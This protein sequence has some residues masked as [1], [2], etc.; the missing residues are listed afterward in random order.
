MEA[1]MSA[2]IL[3]VD[4]DPDIRLSLHDRLLGLN[5][6]V[7]QA[8]SCAQARE[9]LQKYEL[10]LILL[11]L[12]LPDGEGLTVLD[13]VADLGE[14]AEVIVVSAY[15]TVQKAVEAM[16][17]GVSDFVT[18]PF[19]LTDLETRIKKTLEYRRLKREA[20]SFRTGPQEFKHRIVGKSQKMTDCLQ[21]CQ[22]LAQTDTTVL[23]QG[24]TGTGKE[25]LAHYIHASGRRADRPFVVL[26]C[27]N[28][29]A[30]LIEDELFGHE[31]GAFTGAMKL[32]QGKVE[33]AD[34]GTLF[35]DEIGE[36]PPELQAKLLRFL[37]EKRY[38]RVGGNKERETD[39]RL[40]A[41][42]NRDLAAAV[43]KGLFRQDLYFRLNVYPVYLSP[44]RER[45]EDISDLVHHFGDQMA[46]RKP[47]KRFM[48][49]D[50]ALTVLMRYDWPGNIREL[51]NVVERAM[52]VATDGVI[53]PEHLLLNLD[54]SD[55][56]LVAVKSYKEQ[57]NEYERSILIAVLEQTGWNQTEAA[58]RLNLNRTHFI[59][60]LNRHGLKVTR[61][62]D[63]LSSSL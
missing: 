48:I 37:E 29:S 9:I 11:D 15:G 51:R 7:F 62:I 24:E 43:K 22:R 26:S 39:V 14:S 12:Q 61:Q 44:L 6:R 13:E 31:Q 60:L 46:S 28:F 47:E 59:R 35:F 50:E 10:D 36:L 20:A 53:K 38:T 55:K 21:V 41:A 40:I 1:L 18:K 54:P 23:I 42:T 45:R 63:R 33:L 56:T 4:D 52:V 8:A 5:Y 17:Q 25:V 2:R 3:I 30:H 32:K 57:M 16:K 27:A 49:E 19:C 34:G 58:K